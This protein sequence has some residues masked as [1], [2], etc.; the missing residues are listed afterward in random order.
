MVIG[1]VDWRTSDG[2]KASF[3][4]VYRVAA[5]EPA[6]GHVSG[7]HTTLSFVETA[8]AVETVVRITNS[9]ALEAVVALGTSVVVVIVVV[10]V[11]WAVVSNDGLG[12]A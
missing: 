3:S 4:L 8:H 10:V 9:C 1:V 2:S 11:H 12:F 5:I 6:V 7:L